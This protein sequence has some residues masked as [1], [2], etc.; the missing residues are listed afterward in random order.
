[1][2]LFRLIII[3]TLLPAI[4]LSAQ[5]PVSFAVADSSSYALY[6]Q[7][8]WKALLQYGKEL[9][10]QGLDFPL[11]QL[12]LGYAAFMTGNY[13]AAIAQYEKLLKAD[14]YN[15]TSHYYIYWSRINLGQRE[16]AQASLRYIPVSDRPAAV[17]KSGGIESVGIE[18][19]HKANSITDRGTAMYWQAATGYRFSHAVHMETAVA[20]YHQ[21]LNEPGLTNVTRNDN[22]QIDQVEI[23][24]KLTANLSR[25]WQAKLAWHYLRTPFNNFSYNNHLV[26]A[27]LNL[28]GTYTALQADVI[29]G[30]VTDTS[31]T[32]FNLQLRVY[33]LGNMK[34]Y[35]FSTGSVLNRTQTSFIFRQVLGVQLAAPLWLEG[36]LTTGPF[37]NL[38]ENDALY[39]Y[40]AIDT[41]RLKAGG[42]LYVQVKKAVIQ[43]GYTLEQKERYMTGNQFQ[44]HSITG[45]IKWTF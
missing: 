6:Q 40:N 34:L 10:S 39:L 17:L 22:I 27:G 4:Q 33:P 16:Q 44:Q 21:L 38:A 15:A 19:S 45:G 11:L 20:G 31:S 8:Q 9:N 37:R 12:R 13:A 35:S 7:G 24:N 18:L 14:S 28:N 30:K 3:C 29:F 32:Q 23:Y 25:Q 5:T 26:M 41:D 43:L 36:Q 42:T 2:Q 1:M